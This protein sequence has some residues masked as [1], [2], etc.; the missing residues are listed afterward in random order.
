MGDHPR[1]V[2][3]RGARRFFLPL[4]TLRLEGLSEAQ[5]RAIDATYPSFVAAAGEVRFRCE[6]YRLP[7][8]PAVRQ[9]ELTRDGCYTM[10]QQPLSPDC[11][12]LTGFNFDAQIGLDPRMLARLGVHA[13]EDLP[14]PIVLENFLRVFCAYQALRGGGLVLHSAGLVRQGT[15]WIFS[16][17]SNAGKTT[18]SRK[19]QAAGAQVLSDDMNLLLPDA[20]GYRAHVVPFTGEF[21]RTLRHP[22]ARANYPVAALVLLEQGQDLRAEPVSPAQAVARLLGNAPF[23]NLDPSLAPRLFA[24]ASDLAAA[25]PVL[26]LRCRRADAMDAIWHR[27]E[28]AL[29]SLNSNRT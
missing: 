27:L 25:L 8:P 7:A 9:E 15:A 28:G 21:G 24:V 17:Y 3:G 4:G 26:R 1:G 2:W 6:A 11:F 29:S 14:K 16:G 5:G 18:L 13:E 10:R 12:Q 23:V 19:A 20:R 22:E